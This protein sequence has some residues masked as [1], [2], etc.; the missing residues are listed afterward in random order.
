[1]LSS[2]QKI[3]TIPKPVV[4]R[5]ER[6]MHLTSKFQVGHVKKMIC[7]NNSRFGF[8]SLEFI[9]L[10]CIIFTKLNFSRAL[11]TL[12]IISICTISVD[13]VWY[14]YGWINQY[15]WQNNWKMLRKSGKMNGYFLWTNQEKIKVWLG[16]IQGI[17]RKLL[18]TKPEIFQDDEQEI[19]IK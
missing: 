4:S 13:I 9:N 18:N 5:N 7:T 11:R 12:Y 17:Y 1:M 3:S 14:Y 10:K 16:Q 2:Q 6:S 8:T 19:S 15:S